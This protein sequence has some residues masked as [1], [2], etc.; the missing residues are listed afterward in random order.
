MVASTCSWFGEWN[1]LLS[2]CSAAQAYKAM[3][4]GRT[5]DVTT[6]ET[7]SP[8]RAGRTSTDNIAKFTKDSK[9]RW[10]GP[11]ATSAPTAANRNRR[12]VFTTVMILAPAMTGQV[13]ATSPA[14]PPR[15]P[16]S[17]TRWWNGR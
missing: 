7:G 14:R 15:C 3:S 5:I 4:A 16:R 11:Q 8:R 1:P 12:M 2:L 13:D 10:F 6:A 9:T 17:L